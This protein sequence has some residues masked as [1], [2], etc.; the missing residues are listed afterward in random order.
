MKEK[1]AE[2]DK[3]R[4]MS[5]REYKSKV[6][7]YK[8]KVA[9]FDQMV[10]EYMARP[11]V[12]AKRATKDAAEQA[13]TSTLRGKTYWD[14][15]YEE[16]IKLEDLPLPM[17]CPQHCQAGRRAKPHQY[18]SKPFHCGCCVGTCE[19]CDPSL[20]GRSQRS[21]SCSPTTDS[22]L[23]LGADPFGDGAPSEDL[24]QLEESQPNPQGG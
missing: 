2:Y 15:L 14:T 7:E 13:E 10:A 16:V 3:N 5:R 23:A 9:E 24:P 21:P 4:Y 6:A 8:S 19:L 1:R 18:L 22:D 12:K 11:E 20:S 17:Q